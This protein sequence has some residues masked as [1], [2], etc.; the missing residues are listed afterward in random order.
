MTPDFVLEAWEV[1][2]ISQRD[3]AQVAVES[4][5]GPSK[6]GRHLLLIWL[7]LVGYSGLVWRGAGLW[8]AVGDR[9]PV[10]PPVCPARAMPV[11]A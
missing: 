7:R 4:T 5:D 8:V 9:Q 11:G 3:Q 10:V 2:C 1:M 6:V